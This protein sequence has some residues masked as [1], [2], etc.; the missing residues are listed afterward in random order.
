MTYRTYTHKSSFFWD[1]HL[2]EKRKEE[3]IVWVKSLDDEKAQMLEDLLDDTREE[4]LF[5]CSK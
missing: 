3:L 5:N 4:V 1:S 2:T